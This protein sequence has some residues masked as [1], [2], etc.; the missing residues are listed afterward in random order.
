MFKLD[1]RVAVI[2]GASSGL[3][4]QMSIGFAQ[5]GANIAILARRMDKL[6]DLKK[7]SILDLVDI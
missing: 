4:R 3:G 6:E 2:T 1:G 7:E 5:Q